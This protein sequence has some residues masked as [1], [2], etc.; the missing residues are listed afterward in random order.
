[1]LTLA[2]VVLCTRCGNE[3]LVDMDDL[4]DND[5]RCHACG[6]YL[7]DKEQVVRKWFQRHREVHHGEG[8]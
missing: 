3:W 2:T 4:C 1:M 7:V 6:Q 8:R 5:E